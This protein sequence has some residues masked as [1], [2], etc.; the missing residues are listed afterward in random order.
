MRLQTGTTDVINVEDS[1]GLS[2]NY[3]FCNELITRSLGADMIFKGYNTDNTARIEFMRHRKANQDLQLS[4]PLFMNR[5]KLEFN[6][7]ASEEVFIDNF[8]GNGVEILQFRNNDATGQNRM[9][10]GGNTIFDM[11]A[12][13]FNIHQPYTLK[14]NGTVDPTF[15][16]TGELVD[17]SDKKKNMILNQ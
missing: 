12:T 17:T 8:R 2:A 7:V 14:A 13:A 10:C 9:I 5:Q 6:K 1:K 4:Q 15:S 3:L 16:L 11:S